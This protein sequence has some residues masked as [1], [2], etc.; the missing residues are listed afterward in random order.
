MECFARDFHIKTFFS[1]QL[2]KE[3]PEFDIKFYIAFE[4]LPPAFLQSKVVT[5]QI[6]D[7]GTHLQKQFRYRPAKQ[8]LLSLQHNRLSKLR[9]LR[10]KVIYLN[11]DKNLGPCL[12]ETA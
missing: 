11:A 10:H 7:F 6:N 12:I 5:L 4:W 2:F 8:N 9:A 1:E 3:V